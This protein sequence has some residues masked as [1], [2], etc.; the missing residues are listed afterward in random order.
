[1][2]RSEVEKPVTNWQHVIRDLLD[3]AWHKLVNSTFYL[4][5]GDEEEDFDAYVIPREGK[6]PECVEDY[7]VLSI[8]IDNGLL[9]IELY[10]S[11]E[12]SESWEYTLGDPNCIDKIKDKVVELLETKNE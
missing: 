8:T 6:V 5:D 9:T 7:D 11:Y 12:Y 1:M 4:E 2:A 3:P 10:T